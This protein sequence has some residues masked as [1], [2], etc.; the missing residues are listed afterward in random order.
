MTRTNKAAGKKKEFAPT[1][2][3]WESKRGG[4]YTGFITE[5][6]FEKMSEVFSRVEVGGMLLIRPVSDA[7]RAKAEGNPPDFEI[8]VLTAED[9]E[10]FNQKRDAEQ[11][12]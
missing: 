6:N 12:L 7:Y 10:S 3:L 11:G 1:I 8:S 2:K 9:M 4:S 5:N